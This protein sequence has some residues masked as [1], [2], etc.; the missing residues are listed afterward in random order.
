MDIGVPSR[1]AVLNIEDDE[2]RPAGGG[3]RKK[4]DN[5]KQPTKKPNSTGK[6]ASK[7]S[8]STANG[9]KKKGNND[10]NEKPKSS[11]KQR[12]RKNKEELDTN[13]KEWQKKDAKFVNDVFQEQVESA[14]LQS[15]LEFEQQRKLKVIK[16]E[17]E[18]TQGKKKKGK[19]MSLDQFLD[20][21]K[22]P[23]TKELDSK[24][25]KDN[26][27]DFF[28]EIYENTKKIITK[29]K[30]EQNRKKRQDVVVPEVISLAQCQEKL[31]LE[32]AKSA[33]LEKDLELAKQEIARVKKRNGMLCSM[34]KQGEMKDKVQVLSE[35]ENL[36]VVKE[37]LT[38]EVLNLNKLLEKERSNKIPSQ[39]ELHVKHSKE[40]LLP[41]IFLPTLHCLED[42]LLGTGY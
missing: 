18:I 22:E 26:D 24:I 40:K 1:F 41:R 16:T 20:K 4:L 15:K 6:D 36:T 2:V 37:E 10:M 39:N 12:Q 13:W 23:D 34:L 21:N 25:S 38:Q 9:N 14:I 17:P 5:N 27:K 19:T 32:R 30:V 31:E 7:L 3:S 42:L 28:Q 29:D 8:W 11:G 35:L 33:A